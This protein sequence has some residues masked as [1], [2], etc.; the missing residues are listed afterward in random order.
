MAR[1][2]AAHWSERKHLEWNDGYVILLRI[3]AALWRIR[4]LDA[5]VE[6]VLDDCR[7]AVLCEMGYAV[8]ER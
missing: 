7:R 3:E 1:N 4:T 5:G 2:R 8:V 6:S